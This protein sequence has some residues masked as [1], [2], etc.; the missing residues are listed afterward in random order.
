MK[1]EIQFFNRST[2]RLETERV[3]G[4]AF[5]RWTYQ[6]VPGRVALHALVKRAFF[7]EW[8]GRRM[9]RPDSVRRIRPFMEQYGIDEAEMLEPVTSYESFNAFFARRLKAEAR[10]VEAAEEVLV[11]PADGRHLVI[12]NAETTEGVWI[13]GTRFDLKAL[14]GEAD[15]AEHFRGGGLLISR[16]CP[17]DYHRFHFPVGGRAG[18]PVLLNGPL[19][20]VSPLA[21]ARRPSILWENKRYRTLIEA[22]RFG[23]VVFLEVGAT[24]VGTV[25]HTNRPDT[26]V[27]KG[28]EKGYFRF[29]GSCVITLLEAGR[30]KWADDLLQHSARGIEVYA[31]MGERAGVRV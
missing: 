10:P 27:Y 14:L 8:F 16:L 23:D 11:F 9:D 22:G 20:S 26:S 30:V 1:S 29:G 15:L 25:V 19:Y 7:S 31:R 3:Y 18:R 24:C 12:P 13:K 6:T 2:G 4:E 17:V 28:D 5:L 21:L